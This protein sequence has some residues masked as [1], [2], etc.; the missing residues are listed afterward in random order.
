MPVRDGRSAITKY[1]LPRFLIE[2]DH[3]VNVPIFKS[4]CSM[5]FTCALKNLKG[6][7]QDK[8]HYQMH[9]TNLAEAMLWQG[10]ESGMAGRNAAGEEL[11]ALKFGFPSMVRLPD[12]D[13]LTLFWCCEDCVCNIRWLRISL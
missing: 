10:A 8:A 12:G 3:I 6:V 5:V 4:H 1:L 2:A 11:S 13:V 9:Q 7:V